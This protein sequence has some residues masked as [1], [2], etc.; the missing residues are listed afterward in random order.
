MKGLALHY[1][2]PAWLQAA[3]K[4]GLLSLPPSQTPASLIQQS[5]GHRERLFSCWLSV[6]LHFLG[7]KGST[8]NQLPSWPCSHTVTETAV[9]K[10]AAMELVWGT[11]TP[12]LAAVHSC[13]I[14]EKTQNQTFSSPPT[15]ATLPSSFVSLIHWSQ[16][17]EAVCPCF[18]KSTP[19]SLLQTT[20]CSGAYRDTTLACTTLTTEHLFHLPP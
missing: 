18:L 7:G 11:Q 19:V 20:F 5:H 14:C 8:E 1:T 10:A 16:Q 6:K 13:S 2:S 15:P 3:T 4:K 17:T 9:W 12:P